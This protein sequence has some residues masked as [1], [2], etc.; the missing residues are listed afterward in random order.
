MA[1]DGSNKR[2]VVTEIPAFKTADGRLAKL[3]P[4]HFPNTLIGKHAYCD[5][6]ILKYTMRKETI[7]KQKDPKAKALAQIA[8]LRKKAEELEAKLNAK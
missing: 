7:S 6:M 3:K 1:K 2:T 8:K 4:S 5:Y